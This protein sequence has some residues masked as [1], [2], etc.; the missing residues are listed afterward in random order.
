MCSSSSSVGS[1]RQAGGRTS[2]H[3]VA[4]GVQVLEGHQCL[5][6]QVSDNVQRDAAVL[7]HP[8]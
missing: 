6:G 1:G 4:L 8:V 2:V 3:N 7:I 5:A